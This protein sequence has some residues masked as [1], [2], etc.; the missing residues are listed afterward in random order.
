V[1]VVWLFSFG[2]LGAG[3]ICVCFLLSLLS[4]KT[5]IMSVD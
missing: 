5:S 1:D 4:L 3:R 2:K